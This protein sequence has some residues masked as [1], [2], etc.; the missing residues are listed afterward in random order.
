MNNLPYLKL[1]LAWAL[2]WQA[3]IMPCASASFSSSEAQPITFI[4]SDIN[5]NTPTHTP[6][7]QHAIRSPNI[8]AQQPAP[9]PVVVSLPVIVV[10]P[11]SSNSYGNLLL[12]IPD[13]HSHALSVHNTYTTPYPFVPMQNTSGN[14]GS[15]ISNVPSPSLYVSPQNQPQQLFIRIPHQLQSHVSP[16][17]TNVQIP[18]CKREL[19]NHGGHPHQG[20]PHQAHHP[21]CQHT[22]HHTYLQENT[23]THT[24]QK[25][26]LKPKP[27]QCKMK[28]CRQAYPTKCG[29]KSHLMSSAHHEGA[30]TVWCNSCACAFYSESS[31]R[32]HVKRKHQIQK[33]GY[34][35]RVYSWV[36]EKLKEWGY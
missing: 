23:P 15:N 17:V 26:I 31:M 7:G 19:D 12:N 24:P 29:L 18:S 6:Y 35:V 32:Y 22:P 3:L 20:S 13:P 25:P 2:A 14:P 16:S 21:N 1:G 36:K 11:P 8:P 4:V 10:S 33:G 5:G 30:H 28:N 27:Y 34:T 9:T